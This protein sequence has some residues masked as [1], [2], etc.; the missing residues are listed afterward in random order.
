MHGEEVCQLRLK[1]RSG[2]KYVFAANV[3]FSRLS[4]DE[5]LHFVRLS[6]TYVITS[7]TE[8]Y[9]V[10][11][12]PGDNATVELIADPSGFTSNVIRHLINFSENPYVI[13]DCDFPASMD[14]LDERKS[15][16]SGSESDRSDGDI[17]GLV[18]D[19]EAEKN[20][21][22]CNNYLDAKYG[23]NRLCSSRSKPG[24]VGLVSTVTAQKAVIH[25]TGCAF[26]CCPRGKIDSHFV[27][28]LD[29]SHSL[30]LGRD[31]AID[32]QVHTK[33]KQNIRGNLS[34]CGFRA[35]CGNHASCNYEYYVKEI[36]DKTIYMHT[37]MHM[38][39]EVNIPNSEIVIYFT[40]KVTV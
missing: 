21:L 6:S 20:I 26:G 14:I 23:D 16:D 33:N 7:S 18:D 9:M 4:A 8:D 27:R 25:S 13:R 30:Q 37:E 1:S 5:I 19:P 29:E 17:C 31:V 2:R 28:V 35:A 34:L 3:A 38:Q 15:V 22:V 12:P 11:H 10:A 36:R 32:I 39:F 24:F 40:P